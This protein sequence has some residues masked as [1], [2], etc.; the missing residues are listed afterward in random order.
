MDYNFRPNRQMT[1]EEMD[2]VQDGLRLFSQLQS[3]RNPYAEMWEEIAA[4]VDPNSR[5]T[6]M[7]GS[8]Q[9]G[10]TKKT[11]KQV[12]ATGMM[13]L[14]RF[15]AICD[16]L[17]TP[18]NMTW[19]QLTANDA[20]VMKDRLTRLYFEEATRAL[21]KWRYSPEANFSGQNSNCYKSLG[22][23]GNG[24][25]FVDALDGAPGLRYKSLPIGEMFLMENHQ[26]MIN[27]GVRWFRLTA[28]QIFR[29]FGEAWFPESL[30]PALQQH[31]Q[32][33]FNILHVVREAEDY[34]PIRLDAKGK[35]FISIYI[36]IE[37]QCLLRER[38]GYNTFPIAT[39]RYDQMPNEVYSIGPAG[40]VLPALKTLNAEKR[41]FL[42]QGHRA[43]DPVLLTHDDGILD[44]SLRPGATNKGGVN[45]EG[46]ALV[47]V[48]PTGNIQVTL[49]MMQEERGLINDAFLVS[50]FQIL[51]ESPQMTATEVIERTNEKGILVAPTLGRQQSEYLGP[52]IHRELD[53]LAAQ[54]LLPEMPPRLREAQGSYDVVY[55]SPLSKAMRAGEASGFWRSVDQVKEVIAITQDPSLLDPFDFDVAIPA[56]AEINGTPE[57]WMAG[58]DK[59]AAK[60]EARAKMQK[61]QMDIQAGPAAAAMMKA[62]AAMQQEAPAA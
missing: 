49:E 56:T 48:L 31:S 54:G 42:K 53:V 60:K 25:M 17:L 33:K 38:S 58:A 35:K 41:T 22:A 36:S 61:A 11:E 51:T 5:N 47:Q 34:D 19:H 15:G 23:Y 8:E 30:R 20:Y 18:R 16:S 40:L 26:G 1:T 52:M 9:T 2:Q 62:K 27:G 50:L 29:K 43:A 10:G 21:F 37:G 28:L 3:V 44:M 7:Y 13:A 39:A 59:I 14:H 57:S 32:T 12:D 6:F 4:L 24:P 55:T 45:S 46:K